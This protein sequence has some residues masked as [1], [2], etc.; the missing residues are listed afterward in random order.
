[1]PLNKE[2]VKVNPSKLY[3]KLKILK[4]DLKKLCIII[5]VII[6]KSNYSH[7]GYSQTLKMWLLK[8]QCIYMREA[9]Q[10]EYS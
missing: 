3:I 9:F 8:S 4:C 1:M 7:G 2:D 5:I 10:N 6:C